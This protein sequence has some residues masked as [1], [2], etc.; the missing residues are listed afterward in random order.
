LSIVVLL[1]LRIE[2]FYKS[3]IY[4]DILITTL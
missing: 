4:F 3:P 2:L 1:R